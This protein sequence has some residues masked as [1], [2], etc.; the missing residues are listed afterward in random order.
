MSSCLLQLTP[1]VKGT[2][3]T[4]MCEGLLYLHSK[5]IVHQDLKPDNIMVEHQTHRAV[6]IDLGLAKF[7]RNGLTSAEN[8][9]SSRDP[10]E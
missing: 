3:I 5:D 4:G 7:S 6:I 9:F 2:I 8:L 1:A 10:A